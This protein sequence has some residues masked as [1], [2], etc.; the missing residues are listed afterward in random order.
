MLKNFVTEFLCYNELVISKAV[1]IHMASKISVL[2]PMYNRKN[3]ISDCINS[4]L[5]QTFQDFEIIIRDDCS[6]DGV[7]EFVR[8]NFAEQISSGKIK[9]L[10]NEKNLGEAKTVNRLFM[11]ASGKYFTVL[12][13]DDFYLPHALKHLYDVAEKFSA[14][15]VHASFFYCSPEDGIARGL[16]ELT[17]VTGEK[18]TFDKV[19]VVPNN[20][21]ERFLEWFD[22][23]TFSDMQYNLFNR[24]F[25]LDNEIFCDELECESQFFSLWWIM[26][27]KVFIKTPVM[28][29]VR[30]ESPY[31]QTN[32][33][34]SEEKIIK[35]ISAKI[36]MS[37]LMDKLFDKVEF[38]SG[39]PHARYSA[40]ARI[41][42]ARDSFDIRRRKIYSEG[43]TPEIFQA[44]EQAFKKYFGEEY[45]YPAFLFHQVHT[46]HFGKDV[47]QIN[48]PPVPKKS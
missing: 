48:P 14:D 41:F 8:E 10:R 32:A 42:A 31:S 9:L 5:L 13:N 3:Y 36:E 30:R 4:V 26:L 22:V 12:H 17:P 38:F 37:R 1:R 15:V 25:I 11:D 16:D 21:Q 35:S 47:A 33:D 6:T 46:M 45:F 2:I 18:N 27:A 23:G 43:L 40:K 34:F 29:Y 39:N 24:K 28:F 20:P 19:T 7:H 44:V